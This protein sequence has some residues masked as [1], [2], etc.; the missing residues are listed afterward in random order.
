MRKVP[1]CKATGAELDL[2]LTPS[3]RRAESSGAGGQAKKKQKGH[4][5][6]P[7]STKAK[8]DPK[9][10]KSVASKEAKTAEAKKKAA[11]AAKAEAV[12]S[13]KAEAA[14]NA[15]ATTAKKDADGKGKALILS[16]APRREAKEGHKAALIQSPVVDEVVNEPVS[17]P[18]PTSDFSGLHKQLAIAHEVSLP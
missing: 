7:N 12:E 5:A 17:S 16:K 8:Q 10:S 6:E 4:S 14:K 11:E 18:A 9:G 13:A 1:E 2:V 15:E 3:K